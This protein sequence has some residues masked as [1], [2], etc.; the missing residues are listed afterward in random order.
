[1]ADYGTI[2][3]ARIL[4]AGPLCRAYPALRV[5]ARIGRSPRRTRGWPVECP[6]DGQQ[7]GYEQG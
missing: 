6:W 4:V 5:Q 2:T 1:M 3:S 7:L